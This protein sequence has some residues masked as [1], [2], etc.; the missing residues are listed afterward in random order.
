M[1]LAT[2]G[3]AAELPAQVRP[4]TYTL[5]LCREACSPGDTTDL[6]AEGTIVLLSDPADPEDFPPELTSSREWNLL[7]RGEGDPNACFRVWRRVGYVDGREFYPGIIPWAATVWSEAGGTW[8]MR[9][10]R[11]P[12][13]FFTLVGEAV[14][15][16]IRGA[17]VPRSYY[18]ADPAPA[19]FL[20]IR[21]GDPDP[22]ACVGR[23]STVRPSRGGSAS[24][25]PSRNHASTSPFPFTSIGPRRSS[26]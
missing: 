2:L 20:A 8:R 10:Y 24:R 1:L 6:L 19:A 11:S 25:R 14:G 9:I 7:L 12:D 3:P 4:G 5:A 17:G 26:R 21:T 16:T 22:G 13:A 23:V 18:G 15:D